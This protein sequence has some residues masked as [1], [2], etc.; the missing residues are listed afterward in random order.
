MNPHHVGL[1]VTFHVQIHIL[2]FFLYTK[3]LLVGIRKTEI[4][5]QLCSWRVE[6][7]VEPFYCAYLPPHF[8]RGLVNRVTCPQ[9]HPSLCWRHQLY[10]ENGGE[11]QRTVLKEAGTSSGTWMKSQGSKKAWPRGPRCGC[12]ETGERQDP[13]GSLAF[14]SSIRHS[15]HTPIVKFGYT[16]TLWN[17][18]I[19]GLT[20]PSLNIFPFL[21]MRALPARS[22]S[23]SEIFCSWQHGPSLLGTL[24]RG[25]LSP[26]SALPSAASSNH[27]SALNCNKIDNVR[28]YI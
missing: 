26:I 28:G 13:W 3:V 2:T 17:V 21:G 6:R 14:K 19:G 22:S 23:Y 10:T 11:T 4:Q 20:H 8:L 27:L 12:R 18:Q 24:L 16:Y 5:I 25:H 9:G 7:I 1:W 15:A